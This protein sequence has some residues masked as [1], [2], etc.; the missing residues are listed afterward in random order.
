[1]TMLYDVNFLNS[2]NSDIFSNTIQIRL[3]RDIHSPRQRITN[4]KRKQSNKTFQL[5]AFW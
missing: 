5:V 4:F 2:L 1:M 3:N